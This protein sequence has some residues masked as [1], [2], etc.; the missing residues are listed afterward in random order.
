[1][2]S[3]EAQLLLTLSRVL[4]GLPFSSRILQISPVDLQVKAAPRAMNGHCKAAI[5]ESANLMRPASPPQREP[6]EGRGATLPLLPRLAGGR[7]PPS[8]GTELVAVRSLTLTLTLTLRALPDLTAMLRRQRCQAGLGVRK[9]LQN[10]SSS[11]AA[12]CANNASKTTLHV[13]MRV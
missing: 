8:A 12:S 13:R 9:M 1:M 10:N 5:S 2:G 4:A 11:C 3:E 6:G 7:A